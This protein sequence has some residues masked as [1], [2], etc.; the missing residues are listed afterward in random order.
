VYTNLKNWELKIIESI[1]DHCIIVLETE[2]TDMGPKRNKFV[3]RD[4]RNYTKEAA[5]SLMAGKL[6]EISTTNLDLDQ[7]Q[8]LYKN[9]LHK[10]A[11]LNISS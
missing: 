8:E 1:S 7:I 4:W 6:S 3:V 10:L 9:T 2:D 11:P 5:N